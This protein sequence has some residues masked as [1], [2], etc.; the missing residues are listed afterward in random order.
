MKLKFFLV[1]LCVSTCMTKGIC[2]KEKPIL[3]KSVKVTEIYQKA[4]AGV[5]IDGLKMDRNG[6]WTVNEPYVFMEYRKSGTLTIQR[7]G[8]DVSSFSG[9]KK[10]PGGIV[11]HCGGCDDGCSPYKEPRGKIT[12]YGCTQ[13][14]NASKYQAGCLSAIEIPTKGIL[15]RETVL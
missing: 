3:L 10:F 9:K 2:Q 14:H 5:E 6:V 8:D 11:V 15:E 4:F 7:K 13:C 12:Y 1:I